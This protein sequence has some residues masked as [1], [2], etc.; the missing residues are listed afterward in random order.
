MY[1]IDRIFEVSLETIPGGVWTREP[2]T[3]LTLMGRHDLHQVIGMINKSN[4]HAFYSIEEIL[5]ANEGVFRPKKNMGYFRSQVD[6]L[7]PLGRQKLILTKIYA[8]ISGPCPPD[9][10]EVFS[11]DA[12]NPAK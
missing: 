10:R 1:F 11:S 2:V 4:P 8:I 6:V 12:A 3:V 9:E 7:N 5:T